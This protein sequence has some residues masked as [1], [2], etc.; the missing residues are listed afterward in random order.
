[1]GITYR[2]G[3]DPVTKL[4]ALFAHE[5]SDAQAAT[6][7]SA[8]PFHAKLDVPVALFTKLGDQSPL[9]AQ[10][11]AENMADLL[12]NKTPQ[13]KLVSAP[14]KIFYSRTE[15]ALTLRNG[16]NEGVSTPALMMMVS[17]KSSATD[18]GRHII[19]RMDNDFM[20][21]LCDSIQT[22]HRPTPEARGPAVRL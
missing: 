14:H 16:E 6:K 7:E 21:K 15:N 19:E 12:N 18:L 20:K 22:E 5:T 9:H 2:A 3:F 11:V 10:H 13:H 8:L 1:M 4:M 17:S